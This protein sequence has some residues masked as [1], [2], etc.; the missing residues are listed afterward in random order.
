MCIWLVDTI[1]LMIKTYYLPGFSHRLCGR[2]P[3]PE[4][5]KVRAKSD[6]LHGLAAMVARFIPRGLFRPDEGQRDRIFNPWVTFVAFLGQVLTRGSTCRESVRRV[7]AWRMAARRS[8]PGDSS[9]AY[10][11]ARHRLP[12]A[13]LRAAHERIGLWIDQH[14]AEAWL[15]RSRPVKVLDGC[16]L[17]M[18]D[19]DANRA[20]WPY[21]GGQKPGCGFPTAQMVGVFCLATGRLVRFALES[22]K[23]HEIRLARRLLDWVDSGEII[24][25]DR[26]FCGWGLIALLARKKVDV[27]MRLHQHRKHGGSRQFWRKP[28]RLGTWSKR[29]WAQLPNEIAVRIVRFRI[30]V[31]GFR[32]EHIVL[33]TTLLEAQAYPDDEIAALYARR[34]SVEL[35]FRDIK[36]TLGLD[37]LRCLSP[38]LIEKEAW[39]HA[40]AYN[41]VRALMIEAA[42]KHGVELERLSFKG[43]VDTLRQWAPLFTSP[44]VRANTALRELLRIIAA[45]TVPLR[46]KRSEPRATKRRPKA[47]QWL[48]RPRHQMVVSPSRAM[49]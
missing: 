45:D 46:P 23:A 18:P 25:A 14:R 20:R 37:V 3:R 5:G 1:V 42:W 24:L 33:A 6:E 39:L 4:A 44:G 43:T 27:V 31:P 47:Y 40:I 49:K 2:R 21:A 36:A 8:L 34:W 26:G 48:T 9:S 32:T 17:S 30:E 35:F 10:C 12:L 11:Q 28:Q 38:E 13:L 22:W 41:L 16:G 15:W 19:T 29:E 7:Q